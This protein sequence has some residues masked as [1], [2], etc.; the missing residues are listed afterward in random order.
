M[1]LQVQTSCNMLENTLS[2]IFN[3]QIKGVKTWIF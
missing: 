3:L 2:P 1:L